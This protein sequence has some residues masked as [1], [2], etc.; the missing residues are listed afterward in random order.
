[1]VRPGG[2]VAGYVIHHAAG[3]NDKETERAFELGP[4]AGALPMPLAEWV[5]AAELQ[6]IELRDLTEGFKRM[7]EAIRTERTLHEDALRA[8]EGDELFEEEQERKLQLSTAIAEGLL[9]RTLVIAERE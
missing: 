9:V 2:R 1:V 3:L 5:R 7:A 6:L 8:E 4:S